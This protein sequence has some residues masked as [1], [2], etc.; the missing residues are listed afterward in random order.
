M[1]AISLSATPNHLARV[2]AYWSTEVGG[3]QAALADVL[4]VGGCRGVGDADG[5]G[6]AVER[7]AFDGPADHEVV[8]APAMVGAVTVAGQ[9]AAKVRRGEGG[10]LAGQA[11]LDGGV[12]EGGHGVADLAQQGGVFGDQADRAGQ[13]R[14]W[15][16]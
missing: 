11:Q 13:S 15:T 8:A 1:L 12:V 2:A 10:D 16:P 4:L 5:G 14:Q 9:R 3:Q 6:A 7:L